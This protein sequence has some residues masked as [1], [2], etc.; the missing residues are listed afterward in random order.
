MSMT[1]K[2]IFIIEILLIVVAVI[3]TIVTKFLDIDDSL[4]IKLLEI[5]ILGIVVLLNG[6]ILLYEKKD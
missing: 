3:I 6:K 4:W 1:D 2:K 5:V